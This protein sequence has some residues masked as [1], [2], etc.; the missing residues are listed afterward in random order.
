LFGRFV[1][2]TGR[3]GFVSLELLDA[4][5]RVVNELLEFVAVEFA[6][7]VEAGA[8]YGLSVFTDGGLYVLYITSEG[9]SRGIC[10]HDS[11]WI[12]GLGGSKVERLPQLNAL[13][14][15]VHM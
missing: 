14:D 8:E 13:G 4:S 9:L 12:E 11:N 6:I 5:Y 3:I 15:G 7:L 10:G 1:L 2:L